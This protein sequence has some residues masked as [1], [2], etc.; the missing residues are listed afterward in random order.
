[1]DSNKSRYPSSLNN[2]TCNLAHQASD[3]LPTTTIILD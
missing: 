3:F 1:M 2:Q